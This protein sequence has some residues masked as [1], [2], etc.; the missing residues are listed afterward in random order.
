MKPWSKKNVRAGL[1]LLSACFLLPA[2]GYK[3]SPAMRPAGEPRSLF[4][5]VLE[6]GTMEA[7][8]GVLVAG[9]LIRWLGRNGQFL[10]A[11]EQGPDY[12]LKGKVSS[13]YET[14]S[15]R[16]SEGNSTQKRLVLSLSLKLLD[17]QGVCVWEEAGCS[18]F[19]DYAVVADSLQATQANRKKALSALSARLAEKARDKIEASFSEF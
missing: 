19:E 16:R 17:K 3:L 9:D 1:L 5:P 10:L 11:G 7:G 6:N 2:C 8:L 13:L 12:T 4:V 14:S 18:D 15:A